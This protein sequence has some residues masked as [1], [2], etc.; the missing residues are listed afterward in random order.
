FDPQKVLKEVKRLMEEEVAK[1]ELDVI[2]RQR[3]LLIVQHFAD[4]LDIT[5]SPTGTTVKIQK[6]A[7]AGKSARRCNSIAKKGKK[8]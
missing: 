4:K 6:K 7:Q 8:S 5:S 2:R 1:P 3:G